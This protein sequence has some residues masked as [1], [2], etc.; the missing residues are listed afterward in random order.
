MANKL[1]LRN[2]KHTWS[3]ALFGWHYCFETNGKVNKS[4]LIHVH[5]ELYYSYQDKDVCLILVPGHEWDLRLFN[6]KT[7]DYFIV[8]HPDLGTVFEC[9]EREIIARQQ[10]IKEN[11]VRHAKALSDIETSINYLK[12]DEV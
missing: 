10:R 2:Y 6:L 7:G 12:A 11:V 3:P 8:S 4:N 1:N 5:N 9:M